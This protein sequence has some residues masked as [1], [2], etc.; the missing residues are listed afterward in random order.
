MS[1]NSE[2]TMSSNIAR[3]L[4][5]RRPFVHPTYVGAI[6]IRSGTRYSLNSSSY[7]TKEPREVGNRP[8][9]QLDKREEESCHPKQVDVCKERQQ[10]QH[11]HDVE[12]HLGRIVHH[13]FRKRVQPKEEHPYRKDCPH[14]ND[15]H[16]GKQNVGRA[17][18]RDKRWCMSYGRGMPCWQGDFGIGNWRVFSCQ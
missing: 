5:A 3:P 12:V 1:V 7:T 14:Q 18:W 6:L 16:H 2:Q 4:C 11:C 10:P 9:R 13:P 15:S 8:F 17:W